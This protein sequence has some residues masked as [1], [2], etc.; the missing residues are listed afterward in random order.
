M[1]GH[2]DIIMGAAITRRDDLAEKLR[3]LQNGTCTYRREVLLLIIYFNITAM[4]IVPSPF[5]CAM[6]N[7]SLKTLEIRMQQHMKN[8]LA[9]AKFLEKH[10][11]VDKV[12]HP[13][14]YRFYVDSIRCLV[15]PIKL[16]SI[17]TIFFRPPVSS[18]ASTSS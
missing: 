13:C 16:S 12:I 3:F 6:V 8:G 2:S 17:I 18:A 14:T 15:V 11:Q 5:D 10:P 7:R 1:N 9:V 4:G